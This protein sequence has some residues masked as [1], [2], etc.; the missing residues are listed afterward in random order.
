LE[1]DP[2]WIVCGEPENGKDA[3]DK[4]GALKP[5]IVLLDLQMPV[6]NGLEAARRI[7]VVAPHT[8]MLMFTMHCSPQVLQEAHAAG[9]RE[10]FSKTDHFV[11]NLLPALRQARA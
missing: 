10:V 8:T 4:V 11:D 2:E 7:K 1:Q 3:V 9:I 6:M 5:D